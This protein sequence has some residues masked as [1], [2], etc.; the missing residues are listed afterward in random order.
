MLY[1]KERYWYTQWI[2]YHNS[3]TG[4]KIRRDLPIDIKESTPDIPHSCFDIDVEC[5]S[6]VLHLSVSSCAKYPILLAHNISGLYS[7]LKPVIQASPGQGNERLVRCQWNVNRFIQHRVV[8]VSFWHN[9]IWYNRLLKYH[10]QYHW[11]LRK[12]ESYE[13]TNETPHTTLTDE[14]WFVCEFFG[15]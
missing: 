11:T 15:E 9:E 5:P 8:G 13:C 14:L 7:V 6:S 2:I 12:G 1:K 10:G 4:Q 3:H